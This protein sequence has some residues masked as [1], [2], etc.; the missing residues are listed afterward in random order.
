MNSNISTLKNA[1]EEELALLEKELH[2]VGRI[3]PE[4]PEDWEATAEPVTETAEMESVASEITDFEDRSAIEFELEE[5]Y[6]DIKRALKEIGEG[7]YGVCHT[8]NQPIEDDRLHAN[9]AATT[10]KAHMG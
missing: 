3:N 5:R 4:N 1:L 2:T 7:T 6:N 8:C 10:C 9:P